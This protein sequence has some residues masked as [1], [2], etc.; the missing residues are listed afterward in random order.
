MAVIAGVSE[1]YSMSISQAE[2]FI[3]GL[4]FGLIKEDDLAEIQTCLKDAESVEKDVERTIGF[5]EAGAKGDIA[6]ILEG[7]ESVGLLVTEL[8]N[9]LKDCQDTQGDLTRISNWV[10][11]LEANPTQFLTTVAQNVVHNFGS[12][13]REVQKTRE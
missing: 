6:S 9:D 7:L 2:E 4:V 13:T 5:F 3:G 8:P 12:I 1:Y 10:K 11:S